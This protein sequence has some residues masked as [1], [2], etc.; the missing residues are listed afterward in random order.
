M[1]NSGQTA[2]ARPLHAVR[3]TVP[4]CDAVVVEAGLELAGLDMTSWEDVE[5]G[6]VTFESYFGTP[7]EAE[8]SRV[9]LEKLV[10]IWLDGRASVPEIVRLE[11]RDWTEYWKRFFHAERVSERVVIR[12]SWEEFSAKPG[13]CVIELD[14]GLSFGTGRHPTTRACLRFL[15][16]LSREL[17]GASFVDVGCGSGVLVIGAAK[18][19]YTNATGIENDPAAV[20]IANE[21]LARNHVADRARCLCV[22]A[23]HPPDLGRFDIVC[24]NMFSGELAQFAPAIVGL[25]APGPTSRLLLAGIMTPQWERVLRVF[26]PFGLHELQQVPDGEWISGMLGS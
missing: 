24:A 13:D 15:D 9:L 6:W 19:G 16:T 7:P 14:P 4:P 23:A 2:A 12:P 5:A 8:A 18:L 11:G 22:D 26:E 10:G 3:L 25:L 21:N 1:M 20:K 17:P